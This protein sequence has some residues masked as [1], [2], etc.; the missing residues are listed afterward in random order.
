ML[1]GF[2][3]QDVMPVAVIAWLLISA[4]ALAFSI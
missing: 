1:K 2:R 3:S 4:G